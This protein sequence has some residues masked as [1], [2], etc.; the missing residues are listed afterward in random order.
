[1]LS[2]Y[3]PSTNIVPGYTQKIANTVLD[4]DQPLLATVVDGYCSPRCSDD[5]RGLRSCLRASKRQLDVAIHE[6]KV[7]LAKILPR[8][9]GLPDVTEARTSLVAGNVHGIRK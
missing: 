8:V 2:R 4:P 7:E 1:M 6:R 3:E 9:V 5:F